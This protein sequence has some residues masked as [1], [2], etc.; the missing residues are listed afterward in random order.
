MW[1]ASGAEAGRRAVVSPRLVPQLLRR[2][3]TDLC[4]DYGTK[5]KLQLL[6][7]VTLFDQIYNTLIISILHIILNDFKV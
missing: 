4:T 2:F 5:G 3:Y 7:Y 1:K 6:R